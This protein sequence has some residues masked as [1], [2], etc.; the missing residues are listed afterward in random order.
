MKIIQGKG[1]SMSLLN[2]LIEQAKN[3]R[4]LVGSIMLSIM[5]NAHNGMNNWA[6]ELVKV[7]DDAVML[8]IGTGGGQTLYK[9][10][11]IIMSGKLFGI[12]Y[13]EDAV[14]KSIKLN[15]MDV[16]KGKTYIQ[17]ASVSKLPFAEKT[18]DLI[19]AFQTHYFWPDLENDVKEV[20]RVLK[21][22][23][24]F[25]MVAEL[26]KINYHMKSYKTK[27]ELE[28]LFNKLGFESVHFYESKGWLCT[29]GVK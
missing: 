11:K 2:R 15:K 16:E 19:T 3:P 1:A 10:S 7:R 28:H 4:G 6:L 29:L 14:K 12:D 9:M 8:D 13:S 25:V 24:T 27:E 17:Q 5:N 22:G 18:F 23:G 20:Y 21:Q 26:Y